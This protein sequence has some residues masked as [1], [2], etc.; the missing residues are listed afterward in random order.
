MV[1]ANA[2]REVFT[3][4][5]AAFSAGKPDEMA[6][7]YAADGWIEDPVGSPRHEG[8]EAVRKFY[9]LVVNG[10]ARLELTGPVRVAGLEAAAPMRVILP[11]EQGTQCIDIIDVMTFNEDGKITSMR[12]FWS[13]DSIHPA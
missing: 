13:V 7:L 9:H 6:A 4:Y 2:I 3:K 12:A 1:D 8:I 5:T 11:G 10:V